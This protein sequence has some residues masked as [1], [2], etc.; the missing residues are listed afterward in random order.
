MHK[1]KLW[2]VVGAACIGLMAATLSTVANPFSASAA[3]GPCAGTLKTS[4]PLK[5]DGKTIA[6]LRLYVSNGQAC[7][8]LDRTKSGAKVKMSVGFAGK[9]PDSG[10]FGSYA[11][12]VYISASNK[13]VT[14]TGTMSGVSVSASVKVPKKTAG[15]GGGGGNEPTLLLKGLYL[16]NNRQQLVVDDFINKLKESSLYTVDK[17]HIVRTLPNEQEWAY[18]FQI[19]LGLKTSIVST[20]NEK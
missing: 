9:T 16:F 20:T 2:A 11:G 7:A 8:R 17:D 13:T 15:G 10:N 18:E 5:K 6:T 1:R 14:A 12:P 3:T 19:P 4:A